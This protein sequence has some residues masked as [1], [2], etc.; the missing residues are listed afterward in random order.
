[1]IQMLETYIMYFHLI[2]QE[3]HRE[4]VLAIVYKYLTKFDII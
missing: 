3:K 2:F 1:M 4:D